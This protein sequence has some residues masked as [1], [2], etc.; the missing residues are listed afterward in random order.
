MMMLRRSIQMIACLLALV[1]C[2]LCLANSDADYYNSDHNDYDYPDYPPSYQDNNCSS[3]TDGDDKTCYLRPAMIP[4]IL[5]RN[6]V[7]LPL[8]SLGTSHFAAFGGAPHLDNYVENQTFTGFYPAV[9]YRQIELALQNGVR[10]FDTALMYG[11][12]PHLGQ[13]LGQWWA[14]G[15]L[16]SR[17][18]VFITTKVFHKPEPKFGLKRNHMFDMHRMTP[19]QV[20][21][22]TEDHIELCLKELQIGYIDLLLMHWPSGVGHD[23]TMARQRRLAAW[24]VFEDFYARGWLRAIGVANFSPKHIDQ[25]MQDGATIWPMVNQIEASPYI[26]Y[27]DIWEYCHDNAIQLQAFSPLGNGR[28][29]IENDPVLLEL[30]DQYNKDVGQIAL[31]YLIQRGYAVAVRTNSP[32]RMI[33]NWQLFDFELSNEDMETIFALSQHGSLNGTWGLPRPHDLP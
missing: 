21:I 25:L 22:Q 19:E 7:G 31:R 1:G 15:R 6:G 4:T 11:T 26:S 2:K 3:A 10:S 13:V 29:N 16:E 28:M 14:H 30:A 12:Q 27:E 32:Q 5:L 20:T 18:E 8:V 24:K 17:T 33:T 9:A 23:E